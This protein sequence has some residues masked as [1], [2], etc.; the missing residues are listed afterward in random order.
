MKKHL[1]FCCVEH[2]FPPAPSSPAVYISCSPTAPLRQSSAGSFRRTLQSAKPAQRSRRTGLPVYIQAGI[3]YCTVHP[4]QPGGP[5]MATPLSGLSWVKVRL[6]LPVQKTNR[7]LLASQSVIRGSVSGFHSSPP[8]P[9]TPR[10]HH[11]TSTQISRCLW[12]T[13]LHMLEWSPSDGLHA[14]F[15]RPFSSES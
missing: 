3:V 14:P 13:T 2:G 10:P 1:V 5:V 6:K 12:P 11:I 15:P 8:T 4:M 7:P 9:S